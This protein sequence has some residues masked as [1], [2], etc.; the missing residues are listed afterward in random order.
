MARKALNIL[1]LNDAIPNQIYPQNNLKSALISSS[2]SSS[3]SSTSSSSSHHLKKNT[4]FMKGSNDFLSSN[5]NRTAISSMSSGVNKT[6]LGTSSIA[7]SK[8]FNKK[9]KENLI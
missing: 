3:S 5:L 9:K 1:G 4:N 8:F 2:S 6:I 7:F